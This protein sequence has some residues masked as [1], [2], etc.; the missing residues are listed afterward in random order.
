MA[1]NR[2]NVGD[3]VYLRS[4]AQIGFLESYRV[5]EVFQA[6]RNRWLY[7]VDI[8]QKPPSSQTVGDQ[9]DLKSGTR[10]I[11]DED[12]LLVFCEA[13]TIIVD[14]LRR[15]LTA[16]QARLDARCPSVGSTGS[17]GSG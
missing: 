11:F 12:E 10:L 14:F 7:R 13:Q 15:R 2:F 16:E 4:S 17:T 1:I 6:V 3:L 8:D 5:T 9:I